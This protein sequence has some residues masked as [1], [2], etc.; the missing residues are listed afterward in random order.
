M[1]VSAEGNTRY[2][3][4]ILLCALG[5]FLIVGQNIAKDII[6]N[7]F[8]AGLLLVGLAILI[9][10][11]KRDVRRSE[12]LLPI[13]GGALLI[14]L[15][16]WIIFYTGQFDAMLNIVI[17]LLVILGGFNWFA[18]GWALGRNILLM[19]L[20]AAAIAMGIVI[21]S[22]LNA[23]TTVIFITEGVSLIYSAIVG[24]ICESR[25]IG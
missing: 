14:L 10:P 23:A 9:S 5:V 25:R 8:G 21:L 19:L 24:F 22:T 6:Y 11:W 4:W 15:G 16:L 13:L 7:I 1:N 2:L 12:L 18:T 20:G 3:K 17:G